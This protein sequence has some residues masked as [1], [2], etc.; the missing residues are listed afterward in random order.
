[1]FIALEEV[2]SKTEDLRFVGVSG[3]GKWAPGRRWPTRWTGF[4]V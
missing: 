3:A 2:T 4:A 1:M